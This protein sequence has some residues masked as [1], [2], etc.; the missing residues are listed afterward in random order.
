MQLKMSAD[1]LVSLQ[2][3]CQL[4]LYEMTL[5]GLEAYELNKSWSLNIHVQPGYEASFHGSANM[6]MF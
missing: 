1:H 2:D 5:S 6:G 4:S 3:S